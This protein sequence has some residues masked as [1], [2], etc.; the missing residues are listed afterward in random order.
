M[1]KWKT[2]RFSVNQHSR[3]NGDDAASQSGTGVTS[4]GAAV[5]VFESAEIVFC[6][7]NDKSP[8]DDRLRSAERDDSIDHVDD[9]NAVAVGH[10]VAQIAGVTLVCS[11]FG[12]AVKGL[13]RIE[14]RSGRVA[15]VGEHVAV[16]MDVE[17]VVARSQASDATDDS[18][19]A[20]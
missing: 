6:G 2:N 20:S 5:V 19:S 18:H 10:D 3:Y 16:L 12:S 15:A 17:T 4:F 1:I 13:A 14:M 8:S 9:G 11:V 7:V